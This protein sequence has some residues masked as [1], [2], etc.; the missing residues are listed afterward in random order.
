[1]DGCFLDDEDFFLDFLLELAR[2]L[3][4]EELRLEPLLLDR[5]TF[6]DDREA[7]E[8][9]FRDLEAFDLDRLTFPDDREA[10]EELFIDLEDF[11]DRETD[12]D[13][14]LDLDLDLD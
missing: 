12:A 9:L 8:E 5:L 2:L 7:L 14:D 4:G 6:P 13:F 3:D 11:D 1:M 10:L